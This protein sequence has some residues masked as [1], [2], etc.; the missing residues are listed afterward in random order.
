MIHQKYSRILT[1]SLNDDDFHFSIGTGECVERDHMPWVFCDASE[2]HC[3]DMK[4]FH[5]EVTIVKL[6]FGTIKV[7]NCHLENDA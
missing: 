6:S 3:F 4:I 5:S 1:T 7:F 2:F